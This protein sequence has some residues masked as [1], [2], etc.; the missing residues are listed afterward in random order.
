MSRLITL[1]EFA[2]WGSGQVPGLAV[3][4]S[5]AGAFGRA[6]WNQVAV[7]GWAHQVTVCAGL[8][9]SVC[10][11]SWA[12]SGCGVLP[13]VMS[14]AVPLVAG[15]VRPPDVHDLDGQ[16]ASRAEDLVRHRGGVQQT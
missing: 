16:V 4:W 5:H 2:V 14:W 1:R 15:L 6:G 8:A 3:G 9:E 11:R 12:A 13:G 7:G 10:I